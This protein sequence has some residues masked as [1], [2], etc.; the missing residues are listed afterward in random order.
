MSISQSSVVNES[1]FPSK[2]ILGP[3]APFG[4]RFCQHSTNTIN[5]LINT[6]I[7]K[8]KTLYPILAPPSRR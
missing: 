2:L 4:E 5:E 7:M 6:S 3:T 1:V 8:T